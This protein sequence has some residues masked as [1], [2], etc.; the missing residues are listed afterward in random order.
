[1]AAP[2]RGPVLEVRDLLTHFYTDAGLSR[3]VD[4]VS[5]EIGAGKTLALVGESGCG[6]S[7]TALS[8]MRLI[9][10]PPGK[11]VGGSIKLHGNELLALPEA[12]MRRVRGNGI[13]MVFQEPMT[14]LN[15]VFRVGSQIA[16]AVRV[17]RPMSKKEA[18][19]HAI[20]LL[21]RVGIP[22]PDERVDDYPHQMSG[23]M[24]Q[25]VMI[26]MA[27][28]CDPDLLIADEPTTALDVTIQAQI[29][30]LLRKLQSD[31]G[32]AILLITHNL[33]I[34][35]EMADDVAIMYAGKIVERGSMRAIFEAPSH[36]YTVGLFYSLPNIHKP[37]ERLHPI[38][39]SVP[40]ATR[41]PDG[42]RFHPRC[43]HIMDVCR[44]EHPALASTAPGHD[45]ACWLHDG[46]TMARAGRPTG[47]P[48]VE[49][50]A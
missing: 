45:A 12:E 16:S 35:A 13:S 22:A 25:R 2:K 37:G 19:E 4:G 34:V 44:A 11:I 1:M 31:S 38:R 27:L 30:D 20:E 29:L 9:P 50:E 46:P 21:Y 24:R 10:D 15:P 14:A 36:P 49:V 39:G 26:A 3:A 23:G 8:I 17:H 33:G 47:V 32:M 18:R 6:K 48:A 28:A 43:P 40:P 7:V 42:C 5:F 41:F